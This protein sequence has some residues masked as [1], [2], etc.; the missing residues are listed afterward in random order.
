MEPAASDSSQTPAWAE[1]EVKLHHQAEQRCKHLGCKYMPCVRQGG[2]QARCRKILYD[3][4]DCKKTQYEL[5]L[6]QYQES[7]SIPGMAKIRKTD[8]V[9][10]MYRKG[11]V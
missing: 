6:S 2:D 3:F 4:E 1:I 11:S 10:D 9:R 5:L 8:N 7:G